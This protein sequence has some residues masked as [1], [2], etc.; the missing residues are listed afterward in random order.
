MIESL[1]LIDDMMW[2]AE[3]PKMVPAAFSL[4]GWHFFFQRGGIH[5]QFLP[6]KLRFRGILGDAQRQRAWWIRAIRHFGLFYPHTFN[7][8]HSIFVIK[9]G[10]PYSDKNSDDE[11]GGK[12]GREREQD[13][14]RWWRE[15]IYFFWLHTRLETPR[16][17]GILFSPHIISKGTYQISEIPFSRMRRHIFSS[18]FISGTRAKARGTT[19]PTKNQVEIF[20]CN[21]SG[22]FLLFGTFYASV[23]D[24]YE[25]TFGLRLSWRCKH[26]M[27]SWK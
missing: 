15:G 6:R 13:E 10:N 25:P 23:L 19:C 4:L 11:K 9:M 3:G 2:V 1:C 17:A 12:R 18:L 16:E 27:D 26:Q 7:A 22:V 24:K 21:D 8:N 5:L 20:L 14:R